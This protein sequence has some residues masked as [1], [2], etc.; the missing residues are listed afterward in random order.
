MNRKNIT[1]LA[2]LVPVTSL[3]LRSPITAVGPVVDLIR[4]DLGSS[5]AVLSLLTT[6]ALI[7]F[8]LVSPLAGRIGRMLGTGRTIIVSLLTVMAGILIRSYFGLAGI[9]LGTVLLGAGIA[10]VNVLIP[11][12]IKKEFSEKAGLMTGLFTMGMAFFSGLSAAVSRPLADAGLGWRHSL[13]VWSILALVCAV[14]WIPYRKLRTGLKTDSLKSWGKMLRSSAAWRVTVLMAAQSF[15]FYCF[16][17]WLPSI[18]VERS[19]DPVTAGYYTFGYQLMGIPASFLIP[20]LAGKLKDQKKLILLLGL[21]YSGAFATVLFGQSPAVLLIGTLLCG[22]CTNSCFSLCMVLIPLR[23]SSPDE[24]AKL[25]GMV[26][27]IGYGVAAAGPLIMG[28]LYDAVG[29]FRI[30]LL[31][32][33]AV[34]LTITGLSGWIGEAKMLEA[35]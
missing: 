27:S 2:V 8:A 11:V 30:P 5:S 17:A 12:L 18:L 13:A 22:F 24:A 34:A 3:L 16:V 32:L 9:L 4:A 21:V 15:L 1:L 28:I 35:E 10:V 25:S 29:S 14:L 19:V 20:S 6:F 7:M 23:T 33:A 26:Q 31:I